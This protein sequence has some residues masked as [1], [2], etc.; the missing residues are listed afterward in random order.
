VNPC[1]Q[2]GP[3]YMPMWVPFTCRR[4]SLLHADYQRKRRNSCGGGLGRPRPLGA[5]VCRTCVGPEQVGHITLIASVEQT[6]A[7]RIGAHEAIPGTVPAWKSS[8]HRFVFTWPCGRFSRSVAARPSFLL[9]LWRSLRWEANMPQ[10]RFCV[11]LTTR[12][13]CSAQF[14]A[15]W[16]W[17]ALRHHRV[18]P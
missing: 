6:E 7:R 18:H 12:G 13:R 15:E 16:P 5:S 17:P 11:A 10:L 9:F 8:T 14:P 1:T 3:F 2:V 4:G